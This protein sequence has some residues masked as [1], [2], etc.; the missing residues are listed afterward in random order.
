[1][2][3]G[4]VG[5]VATALILLAICLKSQHQL[6]GIVMQGLAA[7]TFAMTFP[8]LEAAHAAAYVPIMLLGL[9]LSSA[10]PQVHALIG[11]HAILAAIRFFSWL[12]SLM[13]QT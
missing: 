12:C 1:M 10:H 4:S 11:V 8:R 9:P 7:T 3:D 2:E 13:W 5:Y 6:A